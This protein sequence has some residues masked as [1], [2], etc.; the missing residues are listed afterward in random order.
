M[1]TRVIEKFVAQISADRTEF[2]NE[3]QKSAEEAK[4]WGADVGRQL[5]NAAKIG[6]GI[7]AGV[8]VAAAATFNETRK[9]IDAQAKLAD[10]TNSSVREFQQGA[11]AV[12][13]LGV[14]Q[15][16]YADILKDV[17]DK[18]GD[19][20]TT[21]GGPMRDFFEEIAPKV[22]VTAEQ[23]RNLSGRD[24][25]Q[26]YVSSLDKANLS[27]QEMTFF[28]E[29]IA[30]DSA[31]LLPVFKDNGAAL[32]EMADEA[33]RLG[34]T[35]SEVDA[36][37][38]EAAND[39]ITRA[40]AVSKGFA[41]RLTVE[42]APA[43]Q[44]VANMYRQASL[45][46][47]GFGSTAAT[48]GDIASGAIGAIG[49]AWEA[50]SLAGD[51]A[52][53]P[54][55]NITASVL[56]VAQQLNVFNLSERLFDVSSE[57][58][59]QRI[60]LY[61]SAGKAYGKAY[62]NAVADQVKKGTWSEQFKKQ[63]E[64]NRKQLESLFASPP[65]GDGGG[66]GGVGGGQD[67]LLKRFE[68]LEASMKRQIALHG[69]TGAAAK[70][71]YDLERGELAKLSRQQKDRLLSLAEDQDQLADVLRFEKLEESL[72]RQV[73]LH[74]ETSNVAKLR[75]ELESG[76]LAKLTRQ[77]KEYLLTLAEDKDRLAGQVEF[78]G[79]QESLKT[80]E[81]KISE[82]YEKR[83]AIIL[84]NTQANG[85]LRAE[86]LE[87]EGARMQEA[88]DKLGGD[89]DTFGKR[90]AENIQDQLGDTIFQTLEG[91]FDN[92]GEAWGG[93]LR[94]M[95][96]EAAGAQLGKSLGLEN[97][98][99]GGDS[100]EAGLIQKGLSFLSFDG[101]GS[102]GPGP[103]TGGVDGKGGFLAVMHHNESV[104]D[105]SKGQSVGGSSIGQ[106]QMVFP[107]VSNAREARRASGAAAREL[108]QM[109]QKGKRFS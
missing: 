91:D 6:A 101:G 54:I 20:L 15:E 51:K 106:L 17:N 45:E 59:A 37:Q 95:V 25:L 83:R 70:L 2:S 28:M 71:R 109:T 41:N 55:A 7:A 46:S 39:A 98:L 52:K 44:T 108:Y 18:I 67:P 62:D 30:S 43:V 65:G 14:E 97:F 72:Q 22:G 90:A 10:L 1:A 58:V 34:L 27:Q 85:D 33:D 19:F 100:G 81:E 96:S 21:G 47:A 103:R 13:T 102:T 48:A 89:L 92:I 74:G 61:R 69:K 29:A 23:F 9:V 79:I 50:V 49:D 93:M 63:V 73:A 104:I 78:K 60:S 86:L 26:L 75:Y 16:K 77:Q 105:H 82:S 32:A 31:K 12:S 42:L 24:A 99:S 107:G 36:A 4:T 80:E 64:E 56:E 88:L 84:E 8:A 3:L 76:E 5:D 68:T 38:V 94:R 35:L 11:F 66:G 53:K 87:K 57:E 40:E